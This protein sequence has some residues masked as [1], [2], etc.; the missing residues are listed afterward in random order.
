[1][2]CLST[3]VIKMRR[4]KNISQEIRR[5]I[6]VSISILTHN[7]RGISWEMF[8]YDPF[9]QGKLQNVCNQT[10]VQSPN[11]HIEKSVSCSNTVLLL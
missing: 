10:R 6:I 1:M 8:L 2:Y 5:I 7:V 11:S 4:G 9:Y 3:G